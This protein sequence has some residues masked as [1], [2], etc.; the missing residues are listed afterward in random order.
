VV[1]QWTDETHVV[2]H[3]LSRSNFQQKY[4][5]SNQKT[6][7]TAKLVNFQQE[8]KFHQTN[9]QQTNFQQTNLL[10][11]AGAINNDL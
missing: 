4:R 6:E 10:T 3:I 7:L 8:T 5:M 1:F 11:Q 2:T 9:F